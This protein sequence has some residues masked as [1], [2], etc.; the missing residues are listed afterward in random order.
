MEL[1]IG[2]AL[3]CQRFWNDN[4]FEDVNESVLNEG[5]NLVVV[6]VYGLKF[7]HL[8]L[9]VRCGKTRME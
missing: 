5:G 7:M 3:C 9:N 1:G 6:E 8:T 2:L 4:G